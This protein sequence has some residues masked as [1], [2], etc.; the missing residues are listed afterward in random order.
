MKNLI[1]KII[2]IIVFINVAVLAESSPYAFN[3]KSLIAI[4]G[5]YSSLDAKNDDTPAL[6]D[7]TDFR[8]VGLKVGAQTDNYRFFLSGRYNIISGYDYAYSFG[9]EAQYILNFSHVANLFLG[10]NS[11]L[12]SYKL[13]DS[14]GDT[15]VYDSP[16]FGGDA[17]INIHLSKS[18]DFELGGRIV[19]LTDAESTSDKNSIVYLFDN[20]VSGYASI[21]FKYNMD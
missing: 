4:E 2:T 1:L 19:S 3:T 17:G 8:A 13:E 9:A 10:F 15:R 11:G 18:I 5:S 7:K 12:V 16:Y 6:E 21:I 20:I 14:S